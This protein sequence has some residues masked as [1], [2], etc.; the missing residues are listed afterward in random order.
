MPYNWSL[1]CPSLTFP[2]DLFAAL[3]DYLLVCL[4]GPRAL[5]VSSPPEATSVQEEARVTT[6][7]PYDAAVAIERSL[8]QL[9]DRVFSEH[10]G[11][12]WYQQLSNATIRRQADTARAAYES[13]AREEGREAMIAS[14][15]DFTRL[16]DLLV[17]ARKQWLLLRDALGPLEDMN[18]FLARAAAYRNDVM[19][20]RTLPASARDMLSGIAL[21]LQNKIG[22]FMSEL[23]PAG[24]YFPRI[25]AAFDSFGR[26][27]TSGQL[28]AATTGTV[29][30]VAEPKVVHIGDSVEVEVTAVDPEG[31][32]LEWLVNT[33]WT[34]NFSHEL[35]H[36]AAAQRVRSGE[37]VRFTHTFERVVATVGLYVL[38]RVCGA[39]HHQH[40]EGAADVAATFA[41]QVLPPRRSQP[42]A[43][44]PDAT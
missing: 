17:M 29:N 16:D 38:G 32:D 18:P 42:P 30:I 5:G 6:F 13:V 12:D 14:E 9:L 10:L 4:T 15:L 2:A 11:A 39:E 21:E 27:A 43:T 19:H 3:I 41:Y 40:G 44:H 7:E 36:G 24:G 31:R 28:A 35:E 33:N 22:A 34:L 8:R 25:T 26:V 1:P 37:P 20:G 23:D